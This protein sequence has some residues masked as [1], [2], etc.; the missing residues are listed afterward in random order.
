MIF[1]IILYFTFRC[2]NFKFHDPYNLYDETSLIP[3]DA[4]STNI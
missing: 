4:D 1:I 3:F 2:L